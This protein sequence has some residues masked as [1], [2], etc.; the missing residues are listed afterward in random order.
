MKYEKK[1]RKQKKKNE[2]KLNTRKQNTNWLC[3]AF[4]EREH[5][6]VEL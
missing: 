2:R 4:S 3:N 5:I 1:K 6:T